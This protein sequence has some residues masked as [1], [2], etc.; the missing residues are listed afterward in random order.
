MDNGAGDACGWW[1][2]VGEVVTILVAERKMA[3]V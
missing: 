2:V 1:I 3:T